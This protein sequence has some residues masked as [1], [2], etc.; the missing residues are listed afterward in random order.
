V[1][2]STKCLLYFYRTRTLLR[3]GTLRSLCMMGAGRDI[4]III[5]S[6]SVVIHS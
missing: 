3:K 5:Q 6:Q 1:A 2:N 4:I